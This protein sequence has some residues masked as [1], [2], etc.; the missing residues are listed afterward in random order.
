MSE[1]MTCPHC[2]K[3]IAVKSVLEKGKVEE[4]KR[5]V[6]LTQEQC[7][8]LE[9]VHADGNG[10]YMRLRAW[11]KPEDFTAIEDVIKALGGRW[12]SQGHD[13]CFLLPNDAYMA[14]VHKP[15]EMQ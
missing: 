13:S 3:P 6:I 8:L 14:L 4:S 5:S 2:G 9:V 15:K 12:L 10:V 11:L 1:K 7:A